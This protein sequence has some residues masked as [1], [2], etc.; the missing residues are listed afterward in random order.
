MRERTVQLGFVV[1]LILLG[2]LSGLMA[3]SSPRHASPDSHTFQPST[4]DTSLNQYTPDTNYGTRASLYISSQGPSY[5]M[6]SILEFDMTSQ[7]PS[8]ATVNSATL[9]LYYW[10]YGPYDPSGRTYWAYRLT[11]TGWGET[12]AT[13]N[14]YDGTDSWT[15]AGGD[16]TTTDG[17]SITVPGSY[18]WMNWTVTNQVQTAIDSGGRIAHF[19]MRDGTEDASGEYTA[20]FYAREQTGSLTPKLYVSWTV[21]RTSKLNIETVAFGGTTV[22]TGA[23]VTMNNGTDQIKAVSSGV[24]PTTRRFSRIG[25]GES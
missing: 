17:A 10:Q 25:N 6:R 14:K 23:S 22:L 8:G 24:G 19:L 13:W 18:G 4:A 20:Y 7:I 15:T 16:Y 2:L 5:N 1:V 3:L 12:T 11:R 9:S 21:T